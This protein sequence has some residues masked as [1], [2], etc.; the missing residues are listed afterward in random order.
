MAARLWPHA[1]TLWLA[2]SVGAFAALEY[3]ALRRGRHPTL[4][5]VLAHRHLGPALAAAGALAAVHVIRYPP[6]IEGDI[7]HAS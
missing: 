2:A 5:H 3:E 1:W 7:R 4:S 6:D